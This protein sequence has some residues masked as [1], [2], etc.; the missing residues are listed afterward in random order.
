VGTQ[1]TPAAGWAQAIRYYREVLEQEEWQGAIAVACGGDGSVASNGFWAAL[2]LAT[3]RNLPFL[4]FIEDNG[5]AISVRSPL[6][7]PGGNIA[8]NLRSYGNLYVLVRMGVNPLKL[9]RPFEKR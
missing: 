4:F 7:T 6:Q 2:N 9:P 5:F 8:A 3:T 1:Y